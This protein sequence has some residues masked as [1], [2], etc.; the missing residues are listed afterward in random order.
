MKSTPQLIQS[1]W[2]ETTDVNETTQ[3]SM[4]VIVSLKIKWEILSGSLW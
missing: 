2:Q 1:Q 4:Q 3:M